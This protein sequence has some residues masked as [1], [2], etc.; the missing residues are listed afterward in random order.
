MSFRSPQ[1]AALATAAAAALLTLAGC[2]GTPAASGAPAGPAPT[3][4]VYSAMGYDKPVVQAF[5]QATGIKTTL[6]D[7]STGPLLARIQAER[8]NPR[9]GVFWVDGAEAFAALDQQGMLLKG[10]KL[11]TTYTPQGQA[12][13]PSDRA[14]LPTGLT[15]AGTIGYDAS[16]TATPPGS[17]QDL[18]KPVWRGK[19]GMN[20]P[21]ISGPTY[22]FVAG[23]MNLLGGE[24]QG[25]AYFK[26]LKANGLKVFNTNG[27]TLHALQTGQ[28]SVAMIQSSAGF[29]A[30]LKDP[31]IKTLE[32]PKV[33]SLPG[34]VAVSAKAPAAVQ[35][36]GQRFID[37]VLSPAGQR[38]MLAGDT[39]GDSL[40]WP[41]IS[42]VTPL[43]A[44]PPLSSVPSQAIDAATWG[45]RES[46]INSWF[47]ANIVH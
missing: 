36:E 35:G 34:A 3:L 25:K 14:Y 43:S 15:M 5:Q 37:F 33:T 17:W 18:L 1:V 45:A 22:P 19:V 46:E 38:A 20:N 39:S 31:N 28:I 9:W 2:G 4:I 24:S 42:G 10:L 40:Y 12:V 11:P 30:G 6:V 23:M 21:A 27:D 29:A 32:L 7:D 13:V 26:A 41:I 16:K 44:L 8:N 47:T